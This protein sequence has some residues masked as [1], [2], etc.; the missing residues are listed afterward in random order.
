M[1]GTFILYNIIS[2]FTGYNSLK[3][4]YTLC[5]II[6]T[7]VMHAKIFKAKNLIFMS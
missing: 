5:N 7:C 4:V 6:I 2:L 1:Y 3:I